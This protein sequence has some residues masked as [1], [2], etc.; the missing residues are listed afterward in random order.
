MYQMGAVNEVVEHA[1]LERTGLQWAAEINGKSPQAIRML[2]FGFNLID[3]AW[4][5][6]GVRR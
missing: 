5:A 1:D 6:R 4:S 3:D 2:K